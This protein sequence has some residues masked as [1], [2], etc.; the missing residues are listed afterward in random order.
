MDERE[1]RNHVLARV[2]PEDYRNAAGR[3]PGVHLAVG[4]RRVFLERLHT[5]FAEKESTV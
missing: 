1:F 5:V 3:I 4:C 2:N